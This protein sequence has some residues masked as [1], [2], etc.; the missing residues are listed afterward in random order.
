MIRL[1]LLLI[2][3]ISAA[4]DA[5]LTRRRMDKYGSAIELSSSAR[6]YGVAVGVLVPVIIITGVLV[7]LPSIAPLAFYAG[8]RLQMGLLQ[9]KSMYLERKNPDAFSKIINS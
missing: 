3:F 8:M 1:I 4:F 6:T 5:Q 2:C 7:F 9:L